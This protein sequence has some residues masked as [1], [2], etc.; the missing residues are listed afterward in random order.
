MYYSKE[1]NELHFPKT[2]AEI[3]EAAGEKAQELKEKLQERER[4]LRVQ[5]KEA[6]LSDSVDVLLHIDD[7]LNRDASSANAPSEVKVKLQNLV[8]KIRDEREELERLHLVMR[9]IPREETFNLSFA[10][11]GYFGF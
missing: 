5:V 8:R 3:E 11:L 6:G 4:A 7:L 10:A 1:F 9:N 2:G